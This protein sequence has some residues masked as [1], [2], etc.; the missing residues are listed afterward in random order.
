MLPLYSNGHQLLTYHPHVPCGSEVGLSVAIYSYNQNLSYGVTYDMQAAPD[1]ELFRDFLVESYEELR[2]V[3]GVRP[4]V[5][6]KPAEPAKGDAREYKPAS[7][8]VEA[9]ATI[10]AEAEAKVE[11]PADSKPASKPAP[12]APRRPA[13]RATGRKGAASAAHEPKKARKSRSG[14]LAKATAG[15]H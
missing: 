9:T 12:R 11:A 1:G 5:T 13:K 15:T 4:T 6:P 10:P 8:A 2:A 14:K 3:A 7:A